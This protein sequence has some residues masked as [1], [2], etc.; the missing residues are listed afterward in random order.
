MVWKQPADAPPASVIVVTDGSDRC[1]IPRVEPAD[2][3]ERMNGLQV[4]K[5]ATAL[6]IV[7]I[8]GS[9]W[10]DSNP[11]VGRWHWNRAQSTMPPGEPVPTDITA[12]ISRAD[13]AHLQWSLTVLAP[14]GEPDAG[15]PN[16]ETFDAPANG[17]FY[18]VSS[19]TTAAFRLAGSTLEAT[20]KGP[21]GETDTLTC[22]LAADQ[23]KMTCRG[24][25]SDGKD[26][27]TS[28]VDVYDR[29]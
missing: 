2:Q 5:A 9:A 6:S 11:F 26:H 19:D 3:E 22:T 15:Q 14:Q 10:A 1:R 27:T 23:K 20:F 28:Y 21:T 24:V 7:L 4:L 16:V 25:L 12:E 13:S 17:E 29:M 18:P 8:A